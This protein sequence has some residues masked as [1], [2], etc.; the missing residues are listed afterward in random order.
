MKLFI[1]RTICMNNHFNN[2]NLLNE[3]DIQLVSKEVSYALRQMDC[4]NK[5][6]KDDIFR[7]LEK[8]CRVLYY[9]IESDEICAFYKKVDNKK[10]VYINTAIPFEKQVFAA[11]HEL[12]H[13]LGVAGDRSE[14][15]QSEVVGDYTDGNE[16]L[17]T[18]E[19]IEN[20][21]NRF[22]AE[23][24][25]QTNI[26]KNELDK[27][28]C[29]K[30]KIDLCAII[31]LMDL[32]L[33]PYKTIVRRIYEIG[34]FSPAKCE[35]MLRIQARGQE[36][37]IVRLQQRLELCTRNN[38][39]NKNKKLADFVNLSLLSYEKKLR[40]FE[41]LKYLLSLAEKTPEQFGII[42]EK[43]PQLL[44]EEELDNLLGDEA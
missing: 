30:D 28:K 32:F 35:E 40:T 14:V 7:L 43:T 29:E 8:E 25:V 1:W 2:V 11:A 22:A 23:F 38:A 6:I 41:A 24:L 17:E 9:P 10:F 3:S 39:R 21:A 12:A 19:N 42:P 16:S 13:I 33:V 31:N 18:R 34:Y 36:S 4:I 5:I 26:L 15:L 20:I 37:Q 27:R 44:S